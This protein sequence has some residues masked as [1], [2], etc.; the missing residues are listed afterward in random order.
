LRPCGIFP[1]HKYVSLYE[2]ELNSWTNWT[3][4]EPF[5]HLRQSSDFSFEKLYRDWT[6]TT[7]PKK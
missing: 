7:P 3:F 2:E 5:Q 1:Y 4:L 6:L